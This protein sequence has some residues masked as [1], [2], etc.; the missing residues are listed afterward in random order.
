MNY[1][2][3]KKTYETGIEE[4]DKQ[5]MVLFKKM[6]LFFVELFSV[7]FN[8]KDDLLFD[9]LKELKAYYE[10][11][12]VCEKNIYSEELIEKYYKDENI[13]TGKINEL[14]K[15]KQKTDIVEI[16][17]FAEFLRKWLVEHILMLNDKSFKEVLRKSVIV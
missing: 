12:L 10:Y 15:T 4:I 3:W 5:H 11:H 7:D 16:Y 1:I 14:I 13:L 8:A 6:N 17:K 9:I 2:N